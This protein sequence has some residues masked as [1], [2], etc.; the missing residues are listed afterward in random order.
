MCP[1]SRSPYLGHVAGGRELG[2]AE[3]QRAHVAPELHEE[4]GH[5]LFLLRLRRV[6]CVVPAGG[7]RNDL[8]RLH[9][10]LAFHFVGQLTA[11]GDRVRVRG[12]R[13]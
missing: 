3:R 10:E 4:L 7:S 1:G 5:G 11:L 2:L 12:H 6:A 13:D 9:H 8:Y